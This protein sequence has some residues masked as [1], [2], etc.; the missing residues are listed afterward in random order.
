MVPSCPD[1]VGGG[2]HPE[3]DAES[4]SADPSTTGGVIHVTLTTGPNSS[5]TDLVVT[6]IG[7]GSLLVD[8][9]YCTGS[10]PATSDAYAPGWSNRSPCAG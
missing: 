6:A 1:E 7:T 2:Q 4:I 9:I 3:F 5:L 10:D 8:D